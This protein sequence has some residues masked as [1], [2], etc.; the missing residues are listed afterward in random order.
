MY[1]LSVK[2]KIID[3]QIVTVSEKIVGEIPDDGSDP[4]KLQAE[5]LIKRLQDT[6]R[7]P[8]TGTE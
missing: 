8:K 7:L 5:L 3:G 1:L 4:V 6:G 2:A